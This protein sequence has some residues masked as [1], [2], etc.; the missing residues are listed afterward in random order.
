MIARVRSRLGDA[1]I[2]RRAGID[3]AGVAAR[4]GGVGGVGRLGAE[5]IRLQDERAARD[6]DTQQRRDQSPRPS[7]R[8]LPRH[9]RDR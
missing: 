8:I 6:R 4:V 2:G 1:E 7:P 5:A 3:R 9:A